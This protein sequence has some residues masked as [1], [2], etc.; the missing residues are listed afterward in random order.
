MTVKKGLALCCCALV[1]F[2]LFLSACGGS[3]A[4][5][6]ADKKVEASKFTFTTDQIMFLKSIKIEPPADI[7]KT[8]KGCTFYY[9]KEL[10]EVLINEK[11]GITAVNVDHNEYW[12]DKKGK[13]GMLKAEKEEEERKAKEARKKFLYNFIDNSKQD[14]DQANQIT[15]VDSYSSPFG[16][17][18]VLAYMGIQGREKNGKKW[19]RARLHYSDSSWVFFNKV[20]FSTADSNWTYVVPGRV[21]R[22]VVNGGIHETY[23]VDFDD[24]KPGIELLVNGKN[25]RIDFFGKDY[26]DGIYLNQDAVN[27]LKTYLEL[28]QAITEE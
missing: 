27:N 26:R 24:L 28:D 16:H 25:P 20:V 4:N 17:K 8:D 2:S 5:N 18:G 7:T 11:N 22:D 15:W 3:D 1:S 6:K 10:I 21:T 23:D 14:Y 9:N 19:L 13:V 12:T